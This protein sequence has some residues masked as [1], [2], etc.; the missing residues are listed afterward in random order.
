MTTAETQK[1]WREHNRIRGGS[2]RTWNKVWREYYLKQGRILLNNITNP[3]VIFPVEEVEAIFVKMYKDVGGKFA[4]IGFLSTAKSE[5]GPTQTKANGFLNIWEQAMMN[6]ALSQG[7]QSIVSISATARERAISI[8]QQANADAIEQGLGI[9]DAAK[10]IEERVW[11]EWKI[12]SKFNAERIARTEII[13]ASNEGAF[14]GA[15]SSGVPLRKVWLTAMDGRER[16]THAQANG[17][18]VDMNQPF[19]VGGIQMSKPGAKG[20][21]PEE[22]INCRC[23]VS[24]TT[25][26]F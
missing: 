3:S 10:L 15:Q 26:L 5:A 1:L 2:Y 6:Y 20:A 7:S 12:V 11:D 19:N 14:I 22:T 18:T 4:E 25:G 13:A 16:S 24:F 23:S 9:S 21:P 17:Q 8:I